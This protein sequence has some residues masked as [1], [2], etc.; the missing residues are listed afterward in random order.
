M[1]QVVICMLAELGCDSVSH[2]YYYHKLEV[3]L[4]KYKGY[5][6]YFTFEHYFL[7]ANSEDEISNKC[8]GFM[9][10]LGMKAGLANGKTW[11]EISFWPL[12][13]EGW[14]GRV[15]GGG[16]PFSRQKP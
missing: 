12:W 14:E 13:G 10:M 4:N 15:E 2:S 7:V 1:A 3:C 16:G 5:L 9:K 11:R 8:E 6:P